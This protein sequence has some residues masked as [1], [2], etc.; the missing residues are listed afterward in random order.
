MYPHSRS[1]GKQRGCSSR[2]QGQSSGHHE[3]PPHQEW[4]PRNPFPHCDKDYC[5]CNLKD[6]NKC[7]IGAVVIKK[8][9]GPPGQRG[10]TG[11]MGHAGIT[12]QPGPTGPA[13][14]DGP[15]GPTG[16]RGD[17]CN[18]GATGPTGPTGQTGGPG[19]IGLTG[20]TGQTGATGPLGIDGDTGPTGPAGEAANTGATGP[21]GIDG[22]TGPVGPTGDT[23]FTGPTGPMGIDGDTGPVGPQGI[24]G[25]DGMEG[26]TGPTGP[27]GIVCADPV[28]SIPLGF[29][30]GATG[31]TVVSAIGPVGYGPGYINI[32]RS[33]RP[34]VYDTYCLETC[35][36]LARPTRTRFHLSG[37]I[38]PLRFVTNLNFAAGQCI[39]GF[40]SIDVSAVLALAGRTS[41]D[42]TKLRPIV[43]SVM[44]LADPID[45]TNAPIP[46]V[47]FNASPVSGSVSPATFIYFILR[48]TR[49]PQLAD[50]EYVFSVDLNICFEGITN[51]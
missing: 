3:H 30:R 22:D 50:P 12:G 47:I 37:K 28:P 33:D 38:G 14:G 26:Q 4:Y 1:R 46:C 34:A 11:T 9:R 42:L 8:L 10:P 36:I 15:I 13:G 6:C 49:T 25:M 43:G 51:G 17:A 39:F 27:I 20:P 32:I 29:Y 41:I 7:K 16:P 2:H 24:P 21:M 40:F 44:P 5:D 31:P 18:T 35:E 45:R 23:G 19:I 48:G